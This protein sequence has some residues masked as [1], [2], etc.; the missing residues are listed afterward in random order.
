VHSG[1]QASGW[2]NVALVPASLLP[3][4]RPWQAVANGL[5]EG[6]VLLCP[7]TNAKQKEIL[8]QASAHL[9]HKGRR[10]QTLPA[11]R[12]TEPVR[13]IQDIKDDYMRILLVVEFGD[14]APDPG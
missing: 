10:V 12:F 5:P 8:E 9:R 6:S 3:F 1:G 2:I 4:K 14:G 11:E 7:A 13:S